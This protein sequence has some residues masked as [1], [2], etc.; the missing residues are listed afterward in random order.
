MTG[1]AINDGDEAD[2]WLIMQS[3]GVK[4]K[5][6]AKILTLYHAA[7]VCRRQILKKNPKIV[8]NVKIVEF[9][10]YIWNLDE[11]CNQTSTNMPGIDL[12]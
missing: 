9:Y 12:V 1:F 5:P 7:G 2:D 10:D 4:R 6:V 8:K 11:K 3:L